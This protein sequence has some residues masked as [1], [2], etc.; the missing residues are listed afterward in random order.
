M[1]Q[2]YAQDYSHQGQESYQQ[3]EST[4]SQHQSQAAHATTHSGSESKGQH[5][6]DDLRKLFVG[7]LSWHTTEDTFRSVFS[8][9]GELKEA[10]IMRDKLTG[11]SRGFGFVTFVTKEAYEKVLC[12]QN[13]E[14][15]GRKA[16]M[17][18]AVPRGEAPGARNVTKKLFI[19]GLSFETTGDQ[20][21][22]H[23]S[24]FG[25]VV[26]AM[27]MTDHLSGRSRGFGFV[28]FE[29]DD[30]VNRAM[31]ESH[32]LNGRKLDLKH[33]TPPARPDPSRGGYAPTTGY[34]PRGG[35][36]GAPGRPGRY[37]AYGGGGHYASHQGGYGSAPSSGYGG[38][39]S[40]PASS[41]YGAAGYSSYGYG[42]QQQPQQYGRSGYDQYSAPRTGYD[43]YAAA[44]AYDYSRGG[45][46]QAAAGGAAAGAVR[47]YEDPYQAQSY[48]SAPAAGAAPA[49]GYGATRQP[50]Y[51]GDRYRPY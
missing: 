8:S 51:T 30:E 14:I 48:G 17:K 47:G 23:F 25:K 50:R 31:N 7:G 19:G 4:D 11:K 20:L 41:G 5:D 21:R 49:S 3:P 18:A 28:T 26:E 46:G 29:A 2:D 24:Q 37:D 13:L 42:Q 39:S 1:H 40:Y 35:R 10:T 16:E 38:Y 9:Y 22:D 44:G 43:Q 15:D 34:A 27:V 12:L 6:S 33:A 45:Y 32:T 36:G